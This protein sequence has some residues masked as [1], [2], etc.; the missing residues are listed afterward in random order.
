MI[1]GD[2]LDIPIYL[3]N[4]MDSNAPV[5]LAVLSND[6]SVGVELPNAA[7][8]VNSRSNSQ[9]TIKVTANEIN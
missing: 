7:V 4:S 2:E 6:T 9:Q 3:F 8:T 5:N 1:Q